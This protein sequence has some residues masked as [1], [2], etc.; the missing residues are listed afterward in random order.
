MKKIILIAIFVLAFMGCDVV[1]MPTQEELDLK[2]A[3]LYLNSDVPNFSVKVD[4]GEPKWEDYLGFYESSTKEIT[5][6][7]SELR[8]EDNLMFAA[9]HEFAHHVDV[10]NNGIPAEPHHPG[11]GKIMDGLLMDAK[12][13]GI[14][15]GDRTANGG[16]ME[17]KA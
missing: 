2:S 13:K 15:K 6:Y 9:I 16:V 4:Y 8:T 14:Y 7:M 3:L 5:L 1:N 17:L 10:T 12:E 11:F